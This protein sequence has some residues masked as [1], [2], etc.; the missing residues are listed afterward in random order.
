MNNLGVAIA[1]LAENT[2]PGL[3]LL[4]EHGLSLWLETPEACVLFDTGQGL[5]LPHNAEAL[6]IALDRADAIV[7]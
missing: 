7:F 3:G 2:A 1:V 5:V 4:G 6:G